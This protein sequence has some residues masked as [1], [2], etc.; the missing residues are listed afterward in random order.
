MGDEISGQ[1]DP[2]AHHVLD[3]ADAILATLGVEADKSLEGGADRSELSREA[4]QV[5][6]APIPKH[7]PKVL[8]ENGDALV[9]MVQTGLKLG[10]FGAVVQ[11]ERCI[12][13]LLSVRIVRQAPSMAGSLS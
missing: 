9:D 13:T 10:Q 5:E 3:V 4:E 1:L 2:L 12:H 7:Q 11:G 8:I 6:I